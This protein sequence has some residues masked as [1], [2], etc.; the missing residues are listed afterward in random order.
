MYIQQSNVIHDVHDANLEENN[1]Y[2]NQLPDQHIYFSHSAF[3]PLNMYTQSVSSLLPIHPSSLPNHLS[4]RSRRL[5]GADLALD[6]AVRPVGAAAEGRVRA[7]LGQ[8]PG[9]QARLHQLVVRRRRVDH[10]GD[11][12]VPAGLDVRAVGGGGRSVGGFG[13]REKRGGE[14]RGR[15]ARTDPIR[16]A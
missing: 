6:G 13:G 12:G 4:R 10:V 3:I 15:E 11:P 1:K 8:L 9:A 16:I 2:L 14:G 5:P 7:V